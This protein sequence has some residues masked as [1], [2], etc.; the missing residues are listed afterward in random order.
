MRALVDGGP[1][2]IN[3]EHASLCRSFFR[4]RPRAISPASKRKDFHCAGLTL[5]GLVGDMRRVCLLPMAGSPPVAV[6]RSVKRL[7]GAS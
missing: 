7:V 3:L 6:K 4:V 5:I 1:R 2:L